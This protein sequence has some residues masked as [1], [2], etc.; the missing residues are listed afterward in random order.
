MHHFK[1]TCFIIE[2]KMFE[3]IF[4]I[5][6]LRAVLATKTYSIYSVLENTALVWKSNRNWL[7]WVIWPI[8]NENAPI[9]RTLFPIGKELKMLYKK[10]IAPPLSY[11]GQ[12]EEMQYSVHMRIF[13]SIRSSAWACRMYGRWS[14]I[15]L[16][17]AAGQFPKGKRDFIPQRIAIRILN[18]ENV[19]RQSGI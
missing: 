19:V 11:K 2:H 10:K 15:V 1:I 18:T 7:I 12:M 9:I 4:T 8:N 17:S 14:P 3:H 16:C 5:K 6:K 13:I